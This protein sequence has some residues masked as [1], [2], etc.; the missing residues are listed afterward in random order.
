M[1]RCTSL[2]DASYIDSLLLPF[3]CMASSGE[4][5]GSLS[6]ENLGRVRRILCKSYVSFCMLGG[7]GGTTEDLR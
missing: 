3:A 1:A 2:T 4:K 5:G 6:R 7:S